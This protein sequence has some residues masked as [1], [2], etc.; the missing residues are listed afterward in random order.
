MHSNFHNEHVIYNNGVLILIN[1]SKST[2]KINSLHN[3][4]ADICVCMC[5][6]MIARQHITDTEGYIHIL[7]CH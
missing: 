2:L 1:F 3:Y 4:S 7:W 6:C 5:L